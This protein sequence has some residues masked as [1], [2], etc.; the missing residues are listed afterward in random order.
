[1]NPRRKSRLKVV[2]SVL[3]GVAVAAGLT[4]YALSQNIDLFYTP[5]EI[6]YGKNND[7]KTKPEVGQRIR[8]GGMV[9][10]GSVKRDDK[11]LKVNFGLNDI[12]PA[13]EVEFEGILPD[14]FRE[15]QGIVAQGT[16]IEPTKLKAT[17]VLAKHD[18]NY[19][20]PELDDQMKKQHQPMGISANDLKGESERDRYQRGE[21][22]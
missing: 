4:L 6:I 9:V 3:S 1:M 15:G 20:P 10:D 14:L 21:Q 5:S 7:P 8:V 11:T 12:G 18:E 17:E 16:L 22:K 13:I 19:M 2:L